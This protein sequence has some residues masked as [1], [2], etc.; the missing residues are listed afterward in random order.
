VID[1]TFVALLAFGLVVQLGLSVAIMM[2]L[3]AFN[4]GSLLDRIVK[5]LVALAA[6]RELLPAG[7][8]PA[9]AGRERRPKQP[10]SL[11]VYAETGIPLNGRA[12]DAPPT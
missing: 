9:P 5:D 7:R 2:G 6:A 3:V 1:A 12:P 4:L 10:G 11:A 8:P